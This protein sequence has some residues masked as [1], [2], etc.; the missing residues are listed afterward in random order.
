VL[1]RSLITVA[2]FLLVAFIGW[3]DYI[4]GFENSLLIFYLAPIAIGAWFLGFWFGVAIA[5]SCVIATVLADLAG[6][7]PRIVVWNCVTAFIAYLVFIFL[8]RR[9][10]SLL[11]EMHLRVKE[12]TADLQRELARRQ[13]LEKEIAVVA[14]EERNRVGRELHDSLGQ[15][16]TGTGLLAE[17]IAKQLEKENS[18]I[19]TTARKVVKLIEQGIELTREIARGLYSSELDGDGLF[20]AL[21]SLCRSASV[22]RVKCEFEH[23]G[24]PPR[25]NEL[26]T[27]LYWVAREAVTNALKHAEPQNVRIQLQTTD[28]YLRLMVKDDGRGFRQNAGK[29]GI[30][31]KVMAKRAELAG[32]T[33]R[34]E[35]AAQGTIVHCEIP[36]SEN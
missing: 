32:G 9:W 30:G 15:H 2:S 7:L 18:A 13:Q 19:R 5:V 14:E 34:V 1:R 28:D 6:G 35:E 12:R 26:A 21:E 17:T 10:H 23:S 11:S 29:D 22:G 3:L 8:L 4:T 33:L 27:Q 25:S 20:S 24:K 31:L 16:L 36:L